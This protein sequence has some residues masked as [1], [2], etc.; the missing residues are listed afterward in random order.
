MLRWPKIEKG[1][2]VC[3]RGKYALIHAS[4]VVVDEDRSY[5]LVCDSDDCQKTIEK[6]EENVWS[7]R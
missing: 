5:G 6:C 3:L 4:M 7:R 2:T 1:L